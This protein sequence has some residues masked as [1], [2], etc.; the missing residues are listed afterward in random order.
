MMNKRQKIGKQ[1]IIFL[2]IILLLIVYL[3]GKIREGNIEQTSEIPIVELQEKEQSKGQGQTEATADINTSYKNYQNRLEKIRTREEIEKNGFHIIEE[4]IF[5]MVLGESKE[6]KPPEIES[7]KEGLQEVWVIPAFYKKYNRLVLFFSN[8]QGE[9]IYKTD[10]LQTNYQKRGELFQDTD[11]IQAISFRDLNVDGRMD[12]ILITS[13]K[14]E[15]ERGGIAQYKVGDILF[16]N[17]DHKGFYRDYRITEKINR[18][19]MNKSSDFITSFVRD[20]ESIE[21]MYTATTLEELLEEGLSIVTE[22]AY[23]RN[24]EKLGYLQVIPGTYTMGGYE[25]FMVYLVNQEGNIVA[26][27]TPMEN[28]ENL[29]SLKGI[30]CWDLDGDGLKDIAVL[31]KYSYE[32]ENHEMIT[33]TDY[34]IYYQRTSG[35]VLDTQIKEQYPCKED[36]TMENLV[37]QGRKYWGWTREE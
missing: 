25:I 35:F 36:E 3:L 23:P 13:F 5:P 21:F 15:G 1:K 2:I 32:G 17:M 37:I 19:G 28:Y 33:K 6:E 9:I 16:Q 8:Q 14:K 24:F 31:A 22:Q 34:S 12:I 7:E 10:N 30:S 18:F 26:C 11:K 27:L 4:H 29:Y 20:K